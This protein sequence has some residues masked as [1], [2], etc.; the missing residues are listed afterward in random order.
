MRNRAIIEYLGVDIPLICP[1]CS[2]GTLKISSSIELVPDSRSDEIS[3][4]IT[5]CPQCGF[6]GLATYEESRRGAL[7]GES[8]AHREY[9]VSTTNL[10]A[11]RQLIQQ[12]PDPRNPQCNCKVHHT[13]GRVD[14]GDRWNGLDDMLNTSTYN[15]QLK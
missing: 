9:Y 11:L 8:V 2:E 4:Q 10:T 5:R 13:I 3:V 7:N 14:A 1:K 15:I 12:C 6:T